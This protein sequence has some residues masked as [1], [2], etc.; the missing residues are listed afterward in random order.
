M[1]WMERG[2]ERGGGEGGGACLC[3]WGQSRVETRTRRRGGTGGA[4]GGGGGEEARHHVLWTWGGEEHEP[5]LLLLL[6]LLLMLLLPRGSRGGRAHGAKNASYGRIHDEI[7]MGG[8]AAAVLRQQCV[9][10]YTRHQPAADASATGSPAASSA[11][12]RSSPCNTCDDELVS[13]LTD[14]TD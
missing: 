11:A 7:M 13:L 14:E 3:S 4:E 10:A 9:A 6:L 8:W 12:A 1:R 5:R 2:G